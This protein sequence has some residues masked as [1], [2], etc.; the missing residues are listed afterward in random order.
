M[1]NTVLFVPRQEMIDQV[2]AV[3]KDKDYAIKDMRVIFTKD[4]AHETK[5]AI[6]EGAELFI[7]RGRQAA[8]I[9]QCTDIPVAEIRMTAQ[10]MGL[11][12]KEAREMLGKQHPIIGIVGYKNMFCD[13][14]MFDRLYDVDIR[15]Y[16]AKADDELEIMA[17]KAITDGVD[18]VIGGD[19]VVEMAKRS[20]FPALFLAPTEDSMRNAFSLAG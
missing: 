10:E 11:L 1:E 7:A 18:L 3:L 13:M 17:Q 16:Y 4:T 14:S 2:M 19:T 8:L 5:K 15:M 20:D 12:V 9:K 6:A